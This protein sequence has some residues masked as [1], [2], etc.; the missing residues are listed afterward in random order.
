MKVSA[1]GMFAPRGFLV[2]V[3]G[4]WCMV[5]SLRVFQ[6]HEEHGEAFLHISV[7]GDETWVFH[8]RTESKAE[9]MN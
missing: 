8:Y 4:A 6:H 9:S 2:M 1:T 7:A 5:S 3:H